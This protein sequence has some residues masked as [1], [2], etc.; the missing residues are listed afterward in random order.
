MNC[1]ACSGIIKYRRISVL[2]LLQRVTRPNLKLVTERSLALLTLSIRISARLDVLHSL[3]PIH[4]ENSL[5]KQPLSKWLTK[6]Y[7]VHPRADTTQTG[8]WDRK[9]RWPAVSLRDSLPVK[10]LIRASQTLVPMLSDNLQSCHHDVRCLLVTPAHTLR[11]QQPGL[12]TENG[13][14]ESIELLPL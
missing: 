8:N 2:I 11:Y 5:N 3:S 7:K 12:F 9:Q 6:S 10:R 1:Q 14:P 4:H 13:W